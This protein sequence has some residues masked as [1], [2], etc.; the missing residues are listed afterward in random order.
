[1][2]P[3]RLNLL[4]PGKRRVH[5]RTTYFQFTKNMLEVI[6]I[7]IC[8]SG[9]A[10]LLALGYLEVQVSN[11]TSHIAVS[12]SKYAQKNR[13]VDDA[14]AVV[15]RAAVIQQEYIHWIPLLHT[16][17]AAIP[18][19]VGV[20]SLTMNWSTK[21]MTITGVAETRDAL[22]ALAKQL[23]AVPWIQPLTIPVTQL[24][25]KDQIPFALSLTLKP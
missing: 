18:A 13:E 21:T 6:F 11:I 1:M 3:I 2:I 14:N 7:F 15:N 22:L 9:T 12:E 10:L 20:D 23:S 5:Q 25:E 24:I 4:S 19:H 16:V 8:I 17:R